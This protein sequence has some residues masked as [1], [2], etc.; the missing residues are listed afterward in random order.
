MEMHQV[1]R[2]AAVTVCIMLSACAATGP[3][4][5]GNAYGAFLAARYAG[6]ADDPAT[7]ANY[8]A[9]ALREDPA[10]PQFISEGFVAALMAGDPRA[11]TLAAQVPGNPLAILLL[12]NQAAM[13]GDYA[14]AASIFSTLPPD[15]LSGLI[16]PLLL[17]WAAFG[18]GNTQAALTALGPS[19]NNGPFGPVYVLNAALIA[20][21]AND[22]KDAGQLYAA[23][24]TDSPN[25]RLAQ[26]LASWAARQGNAQQAEAELAVLVAAH[27]DLQMALPQLQASMNKPVVNTAREGMAE[28]Y[29]TLAGS[30]DQPAQ[31]FLRTVFLH[32]ALQLRP[33]LTAARLLLANEQTAGATPAPAQLRNALATLQQVRP[34]D[35]LY[36]PAALQEANLLAALNQ[37]QAAVAL[38]DKLIALNPADP[39]LPGDAAEV[40]RGA[41]ENEAAIPYYTRAIQAAGSPPPAGAWTLFFDRGICEDA[42]GNW[43]AAEPD[44]RQALSLSP[45]QPYV[46]NYLGYT[47]ALRGE[48]LG[49][50]KAMLE[51]AVKLDPNDGAEID[52]LGYVNLRQGETKTALALLTHAVQLDPDDAEVN[53]HL[54]DAFWQAGQKLQAEYQWQRALSLKPDAKLRAELSAKLQQHFAPPA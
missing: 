48:K 53:G 10:N 4:G 9:E 7:A 23:V 30:L 45:E 16:Q 52:S 2:R 26:I 15:D 3:A 32:F 14:Q 18:Q 21:A 31:G 24:N 11:S 40:L 27:P 12:G 5:A 47:W 20:D 33:D 13:N 6:A 39:D 36:G 35:P 41:G 25:L 8:Y 43:E 54:G 29:L 46:L 51:R 38:M 19:F 37:P 42:L 22:Q 28:A 1:L 44:M 34:S 17:A 49:E 50:A